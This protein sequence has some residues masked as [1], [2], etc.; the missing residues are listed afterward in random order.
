MKHATLT[1]HIPLLLAL[2]ALNGFGT[3]GAKAQTVFT[4]VSASGSDSND[5]S[6]PA[7]ACKTFATAQTKTLDGG[8]ITCVNPDYYSSITITKSITIDCLAG[9]GGFS[10]SQLQI[11]APG[12]TVRLQN[13]SLVT[14]AL[15]NSIVIF[16][17]NTVQ[18]SNVRVAGVNGPGILDQRIGPGRLIITDSFV[19]NNSGPGIVIVPQGGIIGAVL[20]NVRSTNNAYGVA[21]GVG[22]RVMITRSVF[23]W[24]NVT[25]IHADNG[26]VI[27]I[28]D[29]LVSHN[30]TGIVGGAGS[31]VAL[32]NSNIN[33]NTTALSGATRSY[34]NNRIV[35]NSNDGTPPTPVGALSSE[36][37][38]R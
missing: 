32:S 25:G 27:G 9:G 34:G 13:L 37:G 12:K 22:G 29:T 33:S 5:C 19:E 24:N 18:L 8:T 7:T 31:N 21:V 11:N 16:A 17:A 1:K 36:N 30:Q 6:T 28:D 20:D 10:G 3:T 26:A 14:V 23:S 15:G 38:L 35:A 4:F 2:A